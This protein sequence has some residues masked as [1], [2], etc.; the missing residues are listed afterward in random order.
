MVSYWDDGERRE[1]SQ[2]KAMG[3]VMALTVLVMLLL[4]T[5]G[6]G[7]KAAAPECKAWLVQSIPTD[8]PKL[9]PVPGVLSTADVLR[10][11]AGNA[12]ETLDV[13]AQYW[14]L[15]AEPNNSNSG[16]YNFTPE[17]M[18]HFGAPAGKAVYDSLVA[19]ADR[20]VPIR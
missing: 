15:V 8:M 3:M 14:E 1:Q 7:S 12:T 20:G 9:E 17:Q 5:F 18:V 10:W 2:T 19:A 4:V 13:T 11:L 16:D 6:Q